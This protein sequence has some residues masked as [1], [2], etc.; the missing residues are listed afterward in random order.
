MKI[1]VLGDVMCE[2][3]V[4]KAARRKD[5]SYNFE[6][7]FEKVC[8]LLDEADFTVANLEFPL[9]G[10]EVKYTD[11]FYVFNAP[12]SFAQAA[13]NA[14]IN[15][16]STINNHTLDR[17]IDG[18]YRTLRVLDEIG[19]PHT[20][21]FLPEKG[22][23]EAYYIT[24]DGVKIAVIAYTYTTNKKLPE[25]DAN[26]ENMNLLRHLKMPTY[27][28]EVSAKMKTWVDRRF[29]K[30]KEEHR[31]VI[32]KCMGLPPTIERADDRMDM[33]KIEPYMEK[34]VG[35]IRLA[36]E[37]ADFVICYPH[38]GGQFNPQ[39]GK[40]SEYVV[41]EA[42]KAGADAV[43]ASHSHMV[44]RALWKN[45]VP[46]AY[47]L[48]NF[49]MAPNSDIIVKKNLPGMGLAMH[50]YLNGKQLE[51]VTFSILKAVQKGR[52]A[53]TTWPIDVLYKTLKTE[54]ERKLLEKQVKQIYRYAAGKELT[55]EVI[56]K[57]Y[58]LEM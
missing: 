54:R 2:P 29:P 53:I 34:F 9:A 37:R 26:I 41:E 17:G 51:S 5:G 32:K 21:S 56:R 16:I 47:S 49:N 48:G 14:G 24:C 33:D 27:T 4:L 50:L 7:V 25:G 28:P 8:P 38:V 44:Q 43:L 19:L 52:G 36:K 45:G 1:T 57:E 20:G 10:K 23:E 58:P 42:V 22:H 12:D 55:G 31:G 40:F 11:C 15:L 13:K 18:M 3:P 30:L 6:S 46:C 35:D 39:P